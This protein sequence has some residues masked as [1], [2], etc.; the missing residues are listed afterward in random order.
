VY[1]NGY[2]FVLN[3]EGFVHFYKGAEFAVIVD[4]HEATALVFDFCMKSGNR[5]IRNPDITLVSSSLFSIFMI[6][7]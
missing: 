3:K 4:N 5:N 1:L 2:F 6:S 7:I